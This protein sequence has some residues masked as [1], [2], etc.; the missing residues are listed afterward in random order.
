VD[1]HQPGVAGQA[2]I[3]LQRVSA[4]LDGLLIGGKGVLGVVVGGSAVG[5]DLGDSAGAGGWGAMPASERVSCR[6]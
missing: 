3:A 4:V 6:E 1:A 2:D 5:D